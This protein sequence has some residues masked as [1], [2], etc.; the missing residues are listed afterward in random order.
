VLKIQDKDGFT[1]EHIN[2]GDTYT[3]LSSGEQHLLVLSYLILYEVPEYTLVLIDEP[4][5]SMHLAWQYKLNELLSEVFKAR[6]VRFFCATHAPAIV[7]DRYD[8]QR[9]IKPSFTKEAD[10]VDVE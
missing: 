7:D 1:V 6:K 10:G 9:T 8:L 2:T 4:E 5:I 3:E